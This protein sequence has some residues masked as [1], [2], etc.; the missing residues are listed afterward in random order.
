LLESY[1]K[2]LLQAGNTF[3]FRGIFWMQGETDAQSDPNTYGL[4]FLSMLELVRLDLALE[5][6]IPFVIGLTA[7]NSSSLPAS[8]YQHLEGLRNQQQWAADSADSGIAVDT[9]VWPRADG[10]HLSAPDYFQMGYAF[11]E[12][13]NNNNLVAVPEPHYR[14]PLILGGFFLIIRRRLWR[15]R[16]GKSVVWRAHTISAMNQ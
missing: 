10:W 13:Y 11:G 1:T 6:D 15:W 8:A 7:A 4:R 5:H 14:T 2:S 12:A 3:T 9:A 16:A